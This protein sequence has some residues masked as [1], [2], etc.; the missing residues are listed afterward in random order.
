[1]FMKAVITYSPASQ[2]RGRNYFDELLTNEILA[3]ICYKVTGQYE[4]VVERNLSGYNKGRLLTV[5][6]NGH[7]CF[8]T[9]S[10]IDNRGRNSN[11]HSVP[12]AINVFFADKTENKSLS[13]YFLPHKGNL[14]SD[15]YM[16]CYRLMVTIGIR[17][18]NAAVDIKPYTEIN[19][20]IN[21]R[22]K[23]SQSNKSNNSSYIT[24]SGDRIVVYGKVYGANKYESTLLGIAAATVGDGSVDFYN[25]CEK[26]LKSL[27]KA[28]LS[29]FGHFK[30]IQVYNTSLYFDKKQYVDNTDDTRLRSASYVYNLYQ[31]IGD[32]KCT[33]CNC[34]V[35]EIIQGAHIWNVADISENEKLT[36]EQKFNKVNSG[37]NGFWLCQNHHKLFD[38]NIL[39][40]KE[41]GRLLV[42]NSIDEDRLS[43]IKDITPMET[44]DRKL[45]SQEL[46]ECL[47][48]R[49]MNID[50][51]SGIM[52]VE[53]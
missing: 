34:N 32:K 43:Y 6:Y 27:P 38:C 7:R 1:M 45:L 42:K 29:T 14:L 13:Y 20:L 22:Q 17:F 9:I 28:S 47:H 30:N 40:L 35:P 5:D 52:L 18:L 48:Q 36:R 10:E 51:K 31:R 46:L 49:N 16:L 44:I 50:L 15:Y 4:Y 24:L 26:D 39:M 25:I 8:V 23:N 11:V 41:D 19:E 53:L 37:H 12:T 2:K 33:F 21:D 3:D